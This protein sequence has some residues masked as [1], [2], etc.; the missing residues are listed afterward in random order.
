MFWGVPQRGANL[1]KW[2]FKVLL[3]IRCSL[4]L[5]LK[6]P[7][8]MQKE[9]VQSNPPAQRKRPKRT[10]NIKIGPHFGRF[11]KQGDWIELISFAMSQAP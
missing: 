7:G 3:I 10:E 2:N 5:C 6:K 4:N 11:S 8:S 1:K 9:S